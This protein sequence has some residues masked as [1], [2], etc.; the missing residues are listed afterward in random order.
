[1][2]YITYVLKWFRYKYNE[3]NIV[4][5]HKGPEK[6]AWHKQEVQDPGLGTPL[7]WHGGQDALKNKY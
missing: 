5:P 6:W 3:K 4:K 1:M 2:N 7:F